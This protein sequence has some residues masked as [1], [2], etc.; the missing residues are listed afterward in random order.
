ML[1]EGARKI[2]LDAADLLEKNKWITGTLAKKANGRSYC[3]VFD[4]HAN[5]FCMLGAM[6]KVSDS[7]F[8]GCCFEGYAGEGRILEYKRGKNPKRKANDPNLHEVLLH[9]S[10]KYAHYNSLYDI[11][12]RILKNKRKI[13]N[14]LRENAND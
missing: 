10:K 3:S 6:L 4:K 8:H 7:R 5:C 13:I 9:L 2:L 12:D 11:N 1:S 14:F